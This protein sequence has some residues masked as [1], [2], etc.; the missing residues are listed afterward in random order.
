MQDE[1]NRNLSQTITL[2][3]MK[4][5]NFKTTEETEKKVL[6]LTSKGIHFLVTGSTQ[7]IIN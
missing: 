4:V 3:N 5:L 7:I 1:S 6:E 2:S